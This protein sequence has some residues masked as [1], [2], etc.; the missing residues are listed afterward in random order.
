MRSHFRH[1][2]SHSYGFI[3]STTNL[4]GPPDTFALFP[5]EC[6]IKYSRHV[7]FY[8]TAKVQLNKGF[9]H[10]V[11]TM[12]FVGH[13]SM[14]LIV[15]KFLFNCQVVSV[16]AAASTRSDGEAVIVGRQQINGIN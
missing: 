2:S 7:L 1:V 10:T 9:Q 11:G 16:T 14:Q 4:S 13:F 6:Q 15:L 3:I 5:H 12:I 8:K